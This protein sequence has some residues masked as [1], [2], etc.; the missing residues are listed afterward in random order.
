LG[1]HDD[2]CSNAD[3]LF[4]TTIESEAEISTENVSINGIHAQWITAKNASKEKAILYFHGGGF[5]IGS[6]KSHLD[7]MIRISVASGCRVLGV[8][9]R[10]SPEHLYPAALHDAIDAYE[11][12]LSQGITSSSVAFAGDSAGAGL[13]LSAILSLRDAARPIPAAAV[14]MSAWTDLSASGDS[15]TTRSTVDPVHQRPM[16]VAM[17]RNYLGPQGDV[18]EPLVSPLFADLRGLPPILLQVGD[19]ETVL[20]DSSDFYQ[21]ACDSGVDATLEVWSEMLHVFQQFPTELA[22]ARAALDSQ[23]RFLRKHLNVSI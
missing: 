8:N 11:W 18:S 1:E 21:K 4:S 6:L 22:E 12:V 13:A 19:C 14:L 3:R 15:Y 17:A 10:L 7:L 23:G 5:K 20:S 9:Y 2:N 16:I